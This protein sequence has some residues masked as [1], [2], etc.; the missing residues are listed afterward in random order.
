MSNSLAISGV[1]AMLQYNLGVAYS[2]ADPQFANVP[3]ITCLAPDQVQGQLGGAT[4]P[5]N[6]VNLFLHQVTHNPAWRNV[7]LPSLGGD[8]KTALKNPALA[9]D[10][11]YL[12]TVYG[13]D[14]WQAEAL[15]GCALLALHE[16]P[17]L[18]RAEITSAFTAMGTTPPPNTGPWAPLLSGT[19]LA[20]Q[21][22]LIK[23]TPST[24][25]REEMA[26]LWTALK[27]DY[28][29]TYPF[30]VTVVLI[31][32]SRPVSLGLPVLHRHVRAT[33]VQPALILKVRPG[34]GNVGAVPSDTVVVTGE[35]LGGVTE[36]ALV[37][38]KLGPVQPIPIPN[39]TDA[40]F[41][42]VLN[43]IPPLAAG[44]YSL[45]GQICDAAKNVLQSTNA[46]PIALAPTLPPQT[47][48]HDA[49]LNGVAVPLTSIS[50]AIFERQDASLSLSV[51]GPITPANPYFS[52][53]GPLA[54]PI[55]GSATACSFL[56]PSSLPLGKPL[57]ARLVVDGVPSPVQVDWT[58]HPPQFT[59]PMVTVT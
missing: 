13:S 7:D 25:G 35:F 15:L 11:H 55:S 49:Q 46:A 52:M 50:P 1:T 44:I 57:L 23:I 33:P 24:L 39:A 48:V 37:S 58:T 28:R 53:T 16:N 38:E 43:Q 34:G 6:Q 42:F 14:N 45:T 8:G 31:R 12:L 27:A 19:G 22:E 5:E 47:V 3:T 2:K 18:S 26:W 36:V 9:L 51:V 54:A 20:D 56:F 21:I 17:V 30:Q 40:S 4:D 41:S 32:P 59:G 10:L 29:P